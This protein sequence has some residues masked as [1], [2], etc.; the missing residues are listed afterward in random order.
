MRGKATRCRVRPPIHRCLWDDPPVLGKEAGSEKGA[1]SS[2]DT[3]VA[4]VRTPNAALV[5]KRN[6]AIRDPSSPLLAEQCPLLVQYIEP[7]LLAARQ[8]R[9]DMF[10]AAELG[11]GRLVEG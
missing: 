4:A 7:T 1:P 3:V 5:R 2:M 8:R 9:Q 11:K 10:S 6:Q